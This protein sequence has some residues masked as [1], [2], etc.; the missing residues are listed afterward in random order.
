MSMLRIG[1]QISRIRIGL[2]IVFD[3]AFSRTVFSTVTDR[4]LR[5]LRDPFLVVVARSDVA[6]VPEQRANLEQNIEYL[7]SHPLV[8]RFVCD[9][10]AAAIRRMRFD[11]LKWLKPRSYR[12]RMTQSS[13]P[14]VVAMRPE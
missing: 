8:E 4:L 9:S 13:G 3:L 14:G 11:P 7:L 6:L 12:S 5:L 10:P 1:L 2:I